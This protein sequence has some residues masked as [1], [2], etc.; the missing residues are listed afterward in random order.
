MAGRNRADRSDA[1]AGSI[2]GPRVCRAALRLGIVKIRTARR[3][4]ARYADATLDSIG[5]S[6]Q[7]GGRCRGRDDVRHDCADSVAAGRSGRFTGGMN[8]EAEDCAGAG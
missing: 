5:D 4:N 2:C 3:R 7:A 8:A 6:L 1:T